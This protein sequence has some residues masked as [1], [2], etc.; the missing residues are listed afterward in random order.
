ME[1]VINRYEAEKRRYKERIA[2]LEEQN[3][4]LQVELKSLVET[5]QLVI[6]LLV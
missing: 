4:Q 3:D 1:A 6:A 2:N 5:N